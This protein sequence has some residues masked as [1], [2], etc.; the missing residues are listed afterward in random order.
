MKKFVL[1]L[2]LTLALHAKVQKY[3]TLETAKYGEDFQHFDYVNPNAPQEGILKASDIYAFDTLNPFSFKGVCAPSL[4]LI[5]ATLFFESED[6]PASSYPY[7]ASAV[8]IKSDEVIFFINPKATFSDH[9]SITAKD[10]IFSFELLRSSKHPKAVDLYKNVDTVYERNSH[11]VVFKL[12]EANDTVTPFH[13]GRLPILPASSKNQIMNNKIEPVVTSGPYCIKSVT[14]GKKIVYQRQKNWWGQSLPALKGYYNFKTVDYSIYSND[15]TRFEDFKRGVLDA[16][17]EIS[18]QNWAIGYDTESA[19]KI[20]KVVIQQNYPKPTSGIVMNSRRPFLKDIR[21]RKAIA[22]AFD[23][24]WINKNLFYTLMSRNK[25]YFPLAS[26]SCYGALT[27]D[28]KRTLE[29]LGINCEYDDAFFDLSLYDTSDKK[30]TAFQKAEDLLKD[31]GCT[32]LSGRLYTHG[33]PVTLT[34]VL[35]SPR[36]KKIALAFGENLK[37]LGIHLEIVELDRQSYMKRIDSRDYDLCCDMSITTYQHPL[38][39]GTELKSYFSSEGAINY[40]GICDKK[41]DLL[42]EKS[43]TNDEKK[44]QS[45]LKALDFML[46]HGY[47]RIL[48]WYFDGMWFALSKKIESKMNYPKYIRMNVFFD[49]KNKGLIDFWH[50]ANAEK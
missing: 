23:F 28:I 14:L 26:F 17:Y 31:A 36:V 43:I 25:S 33:R 4:N 7:V 37:K 2:F 46:V 6:E 20:D 1:Y 9:T 50:V 40:S 35:E 38:K 48:G 12:K 39:P 41:I 27:A 13:L 10:V 8:D 19:K 16:R 42:I 44:K 47:Y 49:S 21:V 24:Y 5:Y 29:S 32:T 45:Y 11:T 30:R 34:F 3:L 18:I 15:M 22:Y